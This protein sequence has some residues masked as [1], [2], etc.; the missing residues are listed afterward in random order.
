[1]SYKKRIF[2]I[3]CPN[4]MDL[5]Q[6]RNEGKSLE[7]ICKLI[8]YE[9]ATFFPKSKKEFEDVCE[10]IS[11]IDE[12]HDVHD[13]KGVPLCIHIS[14]HG[15]E[16]GLVFGQEKIKWY[17]LVTAIAPI[18]KSESYDGHKIFV[19]SACDAGQNTLSKIIKRRRLRRLPAR[20]GMRRKP[21][22]KAIR[23]KPPEYLFVTAQA[24]VD[25]IDATVAWALF[26]SKLSD[27]DFAEEEESTIQSKIKKILNRVYK[28]DL[29]NIHYHRW[30]SDL[31]EYKQ[32]RPEDDH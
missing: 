7:Q 18:T 24:R 31:E 30:D 12:Y 13:E 21:L 9:V 22:P 15:D 5:L 17:S 14:S 29:S 26:Y 32:Y 6:G 10:Y 19:I 1:M 25:W 20:K 8:G 11:S 23:I 28:A 2:I 3:E 27:I 16:D 4:P